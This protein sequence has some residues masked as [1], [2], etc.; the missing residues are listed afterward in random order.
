M[1]KHLNTSRSIFLTIGIFCHAASFADNDRHSSHDYEEEIVFSA[2]F[3]QNEAS[4]A[5]PINVLTGETLAR[6]VED[7]LGNTLRNQ[8]FVKVWAFN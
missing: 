8:M 5:L 3:Q 2:P 7:A 6:E 1:G 4:T